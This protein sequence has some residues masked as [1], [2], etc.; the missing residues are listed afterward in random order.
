[1]LIIVDKKIPGKAK[2]KLSA[3]F[4][5]RQ[6]GGNI[7]EL[8][9]EGIVY[10]AISG[11]PDIFFCKTPQ[12][13]VVSPSLPNKYLQRI[14]EQQLQYIIGNQASSI[15]AC[16]AGRQHP[17]SSIKHYQ[18]SI[19]FFADSKIIPTFAPLIFNRLIIIN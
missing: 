17:A 14:K 15:P 9:T 19:L 16:P 6:V 11:H 10:P 7:L 12:M 4:P 2:E 1:M 13:L 18:L 8:E 5:V 3:S